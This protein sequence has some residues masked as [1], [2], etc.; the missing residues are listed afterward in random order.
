MVK[1]FETETELVI[2]TSVSVNWVRS[3][4][5]PVCQTSDLS[6]NMGGVRVSQVKPSN[7]LR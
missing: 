2:E 4:W 1:A 5:W 7:C 6:W 3:V